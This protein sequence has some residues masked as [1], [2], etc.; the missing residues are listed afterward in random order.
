MDNFGCL[1]LNYLSEVNRD[2]PMLLLAF[3]RPTLFE[4]RTDWRSTVSRRCRMWPS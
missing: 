4:Q 2:A 1:F 3:A